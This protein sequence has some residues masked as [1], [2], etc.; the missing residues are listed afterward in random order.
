[1]AVHAESA[2]YIYMLKGFAY[3]P[4]CYSM[5]TVPVGSSERFTFQTSQPRKS[6]HGSFHGWL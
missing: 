6:L 5:Q 1:M 3:R 4:V 2:Q